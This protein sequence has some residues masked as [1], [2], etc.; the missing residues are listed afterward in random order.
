M[1]IGRKG[2]N[3]M[4]RL[5]SFLLIISLTAMS[6]NREN[7]QKFKAALKEDDA[8]P[9][10]QVA[11]LFDN[12][13]SYKD[14][15]LDTLNNVKK[16]FQFLVSKYGSDENIKVSLILIDSK[17]S[18]IFNGKVRD[19][20]RAFDDVEK[21]LKTGQSQFTDLSNAVNRAL[22]FFTEGNAKRRVLI[23]FTDMK[24]STPNYHPRDEEVVPPPPDFPWD[25]LRNENVEAYAFFVPFKEWRLWQ[26]G[27]CQ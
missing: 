22:Y 5:F 1:I 2:R 16:L 27:M 4:K 9:E 7:V 26:P 21:T 19:L 3:E 24:A 10:I 11:V 15:V 25:G 23:M 20:Q 18:I 17:A 8:R 6:C 13:I 14:Y 12:S